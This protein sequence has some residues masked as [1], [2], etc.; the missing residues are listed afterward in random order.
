[1]IRRYSIA[2]ALAAGVTL[3]VMLAMQLLVTGQRGE[4][5]EE[6]V[7]RAVD[8]VR[9]RRQPEPETKPREL[10]RRVAPQPQPPPPQLELSSVPDSHPFEIAA[11]IPDLEVELEVGGN[12][13]GAGTG[14]GGGGD[15][16]PLVRVNPEY[17]ARALQR[18]VEGYVHLSFTVTKSGTVE[19][20]EVLRA[21]PRSYFEDAAIAA[22]RKYRYKPK[23]ENGLPVERPGVEVVLAFK[24]NR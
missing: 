8:F 12:G 23:M 17:P 22:V 18:G 20:I 24:L 11:A 7:A 15:V 1:M 4:L 21:E 5:R 10:P 9:L 19:E 2:A 3:A 14:A 13:A 16:V 6:P